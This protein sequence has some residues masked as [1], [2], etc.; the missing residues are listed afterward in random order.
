MTS[1]ATIQEIHFDH[2]VASIRINRTDMPMEHQRVVGFLDTMAEPCCRPG[3][4]P[5]QRLQ[6]FEDDIQRAFYS[7]YFKN[8]GLKA[9]TVLFPDGM[10]GSVFVTSMRVSDNGLLN[11]S[12]LPD[13]LTEIFPVIPGGNGLRYALYGD[14]IYQVLQCIIGR[15]RG[16]PTVAQSEI[17]RRYCAMRAAIEHSYADF[18][19]LFKLL[20]S[21]KT[22]RLYNRGD[23]NVKLIVSAFLIMNCYRCMNGSTC[24][25]IFSIQAPDLDDYLPLDDV[26]EPAPA[27]YFPGRGEQN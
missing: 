7:G 19:N 5:R 20:D 11:M 2:G 1:Q 27:V 13:Y 9:Q 14:G 22:L 12:R 21:R 8:H 6:L 24:Q 17:N 16:E 18:K 3:D 15:L 26:F 10:I 23:R 4:S 25:S